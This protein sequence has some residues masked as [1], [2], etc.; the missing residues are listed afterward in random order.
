MSTQALHSSTW[1]RAV[2]ISD[3]EM[4]KEIRLVPLSTCHA[5]DLFAAADLGLFEHGS[6]AP[7]EWS[8]RGFEGE[9]AKV[10]ALPGVAAFAI[11]A[12]RGGAAGRAIGRT[13]FMDIRPEHRALEIGRTWIG[14]AFHGT[15]VN[16]EAKYLLLR[17]A[18]ESLAPGAIRVQITTNA[19]N[20]QSKRAIEKLG[21]IREGTLRK[22][23]I[24]PASLDRA[25]PAVRDWIYYSI[26][27]DEWPDVKG[28]LE[29]RLSAMP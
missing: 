11:I 13:T 20:L 14:R 15:R 25:E 12:Q 22:A 17:H 9:I 4:A 19:T 29:R 5:P 6:Q 16:P 3:P 2:E 27:D 7:G 26:L 8:V 1:V 10:C 21:A 23:R 24:L 28:R 18:F